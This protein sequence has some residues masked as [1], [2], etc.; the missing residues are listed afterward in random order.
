MLTQTGLSTTVL[1]KD[2]MLRRS[3]IIEGTSNEHYRQ[4]NPQAR[5]SDGE[6]NKGRGLTLML[7]AATGFIGI[8]TLEKQRQ[9]WVYVHTDGTYC[10][11]LAI[12]YNFPIPFSLVS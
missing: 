5:G 3:Q 8:I 10:L 6:R 1:D 12:A 11:P 4:G 7:R 9:R 2:K